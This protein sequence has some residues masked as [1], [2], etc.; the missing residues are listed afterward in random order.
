M[1]HRQDDTSSA[2]DAWQRLAS[3][4]CASLVEV[5]AGIT[6]PDPGLIARLRKQWDA[7]I[8]SVALELARARARAFAKFSDPDSL[9]CDVQGVEQASSSLA[10]DWKATRFDST[11][12]ATCWDLGCGIGGDAMALSARCSLEAVDIDPVRAWMTGLNAGCPVRVA[13]LRDLDLS[14]AFVHL[15]PARRDESSARRAWH[16]DRYEPP[17]NEILE[18]TRHA[19][20]TACKLG[21]GIP[22]PFDGA[23][24]GSEIEFLQEGSR[25]VQAVIWTGEL[26][27]DPGRTRATL[28]QSGTSISGT[29]V[30]ITQGEGVPGEGDCLLEPCPALERAGLIG[31]AL[32]AVAGA[33]WEASPGLGLLVSDAPAGEP[34]F[35]DWRVLA[36]LPMRERSVKT[37][38]REH[39]AGE[40]VARTRGGAIDVDVWSRSLRGSGSE[41]F[42]VFGLRMGTEA[43][44]LVCQPV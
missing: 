36:V 3:D 27:T 26:A 8:V 33:P 20:G 16:P 2:L 31:L 5:T 44:A 43:R 25:L 6:D 14:G 28:L 9:W 38:L 10:A 13:D 15:D 17:W 32:E 42:V 12:D 34:W 4:A 35:R 21:P 18:C 1:A 22:M 23:P 40:V 30:S 39:D 37:W 41:R 19:R 29:P 11:G 24:P 7:P